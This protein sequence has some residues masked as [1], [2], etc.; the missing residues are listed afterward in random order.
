MSYAPAGHI[1]AYS[2]L[3][4]YNGGENMQKIN[5]RKLYYHA[6]HRYFTVNNLVVA[7]ALVIGAGW[8]WASVD[9]MQRNYALQKVVDGKAREQKLTELELQNLAYQQRYFKSS[10]Y[11]ELAVRERLG[12]VNPGEKTLV[13][14]PNSAA[15][16]SADAQVAPKAAV[17]QEEPSNMQQWVNFLFGGSRSK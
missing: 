10:E 11:Q 13:L 3:L 2:S 5:I 15:A 12:L 8:A 14:P 7:I 16:K 1:I 9:V 6:R 4:G 17:P